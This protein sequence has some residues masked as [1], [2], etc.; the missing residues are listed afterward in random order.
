MRNRFILFLSNKQIWLL[1][2]S[3]R[4]TLP[5]DEDETKKKEYDDEW[6]VKR[7]GEWKKEVVDY[8]FNATQLN[9]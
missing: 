6:E 8:L 3:L 2:L 7:K 1:R 5:S 4:F 9:K